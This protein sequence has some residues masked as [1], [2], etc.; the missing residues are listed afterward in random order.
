MPQHLAMDRLWLELKIAWRRLTSRPGFTTTAILSLGFGIG[1]NTVFFSL[2]NSTLLRPLPVEKPEEL[3]AA[4]D[5]RYGAPVVSNPNIRD[6]R[7]RTGGFFRYFLGYRILG[8]NG[9]V[10]PG[11]NFRIWGYGVTGDYFEGLGVTPALGRVLTMD[12]DR[13]KGA[14]PVAVLTD[15]GWRR[16]FNSD[17]N[18]VGRTL[19]LN[20]FPFTVV[21]VTRPSFTGTERFYAPEVFTSWRMLDQTEIG[22]SGYDGSRDSQNTFVI[23]RLKQGVTSAQAQAAL[24]GVTAELAKAYPNENEGLRLKLTEP[25]WAGDYLR[26]TVIGF[27]TVLMGVAGALLL[28]VCVNLANLLLAQAAERRREMG[29]R[30]AIGAGRMQ[31]IR[32]L[33]LESL[34]VGALGGALGM[35]IAWW[36]VDGISG[37]RLPVAFS[38]DTHIA[39]DGNVALFSVAATILASVLFGLVP[40]WQATR[41][42]LASAIKN[43]A[44][45]RRGRRWPLRDLLVGAQIALSVLLIVCSALML[46]SLTRAMS[47]NLGFEPKGAASL[48]F[49]LSAQGYNN[50]KGKQF[51]R[52]LMRKV[53]EVPGVRHASFASSIP[54]DID[55]SN[56]EV[57]ETGQPQPPASRITTAQ[58]YSISRDF[59]KVMRTH[60]LAGREFE[61]RDTSDSPR[62]II[63]N[64]TFTSKILK[65]KQPE[66]AVGKRV[67]TSGR[68]H[69][70][71]GVVEDGKY[72]GLSEAPKSVMF[73]SA[74]QSY[75][76]QTRVVWRTAG[77]DTQESLSRVRQLVLEMNPEMTIVDAESLEQHMNLPLLPARLAAGAMSVFGIV[78]MLLAAVG[79][80]GVTAFSVSRR[81]REIG[82]RMAIGAEPRQISRMILARAGV[83]I[84]LAVFAG[85]GLS[86][87]GSR[88]LAPILIG[89][90]PLDVAAH[91]EGILVMAV[92]ALTACFM[93]ARRAARLDPAK[94]LR[95]E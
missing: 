66:L 37:V 2:L 19:K 44:A 52:E 1:A 21:G 49:D 77:A 40:A 46:K 12:D 55:M 58:V 3:L 91:S 23:A 76:S 45:D 65:L 22:N 64:K 24:D 42:D 35:L 86:M 28:V 88:L 48:G 83:L 80:Y 50:D 39:L 87:F 74:D 18:A 95:S 71:I 4:V 5:P 56:N 72:F 57:W 16:H 31:L 9:S 47:L 30:L 20:G 43:D 29:I 17:P 25:G 11:K 60:F 62:V 14:H 67:Q 73:P 53:R 94:S 15:L 92:T 63:V 13:K 70:I 41:T 26:G 93:P 54:L 59:F 61:E 7:E 36:C 6:M 38:I 75:T 33:L 90:D 81:T 78:T 84:L 89:V 27:N 68:T 85:A 32:Q 51:Q 82:I 79:I 8:M 10:A 34:L 69:E